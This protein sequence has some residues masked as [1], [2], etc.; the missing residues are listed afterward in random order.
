MNPESPDR[1]EP[2]VA[3]IVFHTYTGTASLCSVPKQTSVAWAL[4]A[5]NSETRPCLHCPSAIQ[6][7]G[8]N[9]AKINKTKHCKHPQCRV[10]CITFEERSVRTIALIVPPSLGEFDS[11]MRESGW[12]TTSPKAQLAQNAKHQSDQ[13]AC[14]CRWALRHLQ[15]VSPI[16]APLVACSSHS[17]SSIRGNQEPSRGSNRWA[18]P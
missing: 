13:V 14:A 11:L 16:W 2:P 7:R 18:N 1:A 6:A 4:L 12:C 8:I 10:Q 17:N 15:T 9:A 5:G 3:G